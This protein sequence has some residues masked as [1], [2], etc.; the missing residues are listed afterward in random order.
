MLQRRKQNQERWALKKEGSFREK[1][2]GLVEEVVTV[3]KVSS[4]GRFFVNRIQTY[5]IF[6]LCYFATFVLPGGES[7]TVMPCIQVRNKFSV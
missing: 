5:L 1:V 2:R 7:C 4:N 6:S 3:K